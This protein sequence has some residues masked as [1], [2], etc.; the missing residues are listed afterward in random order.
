MIEG[1][2]FLPGTGRDGQVAMPPGHGFGSRGDPNLSIRRSLVE[3]LARTPA[4][5]LRQPYGLPPPRTG[6]EL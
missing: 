4:R 5:P 6:E 1:S 2:K 3:G